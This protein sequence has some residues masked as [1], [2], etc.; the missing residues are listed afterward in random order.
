M[1]ISFEET[2]DGKFIA[3]SISCDLDPYSINIIKRRYSHKHLLYSENLIFGKSDAEG[4]FAVGYYSK[5]KEI[6]DSINESI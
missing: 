1:P 4:N 2:S 6:I 3:R 5:G